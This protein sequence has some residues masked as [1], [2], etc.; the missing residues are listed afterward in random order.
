MSAKGQEKLSEAT[1][2]FV[3]TSTATHSR[4]QVKG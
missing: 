3:M 1:M 4:K 2:I